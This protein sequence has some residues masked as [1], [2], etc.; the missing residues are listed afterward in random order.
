MKQVI[1]CFQNSPA[2]FNQYLI[3]STYTSLM[4]GAFGR[5]HR[6]T[7]NGF[8][9]AFPNIIIIALVAQVKGQMWVLR[10]LEKCVCFKYVFGNLENKIMGLGSTS[11]TV[12]RT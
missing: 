10:K 12:R 11:L 5:L 7:F 1:V 9:L 6:S 4:F 3:L 2:I 8:Y